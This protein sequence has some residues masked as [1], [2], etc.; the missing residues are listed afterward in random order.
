MKNAFI[1][2]IVM[3]ALG[4]IN[5][6]LIEHKPPNNGLPLVHADFPTCLTVHNGPIQRPDNYNTRLYSRKADRA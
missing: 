1:F 5:I 4:I 2:V 3:I 6:A